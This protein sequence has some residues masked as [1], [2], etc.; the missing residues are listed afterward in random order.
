MFLT[1]ISVF[2][3]VFAVMVMIAIG[4]FGVNAYRSLPIDQYP[5]VDFPVVAIL[6]PWIGAPPES[7]E[8][9]ITEVIENAVNT[10]AG[11]DTISSTSQHSHSTVV[12]MFDLDTDSM[13]AAQEVRD[14]IAAVIPQLP[15]D[16]NSPTVVRFNPTSAP[17]LSLAIS[18]E[19]RS[20]T[21]LTTLAEDVI[22]PALTAIDGVGSANVVGAVEDEVEVLIDPDRLR[23]FNLGV[24]DVVAALRSDN[25]I[26]P[27]GSVIDG[28]L[29]QSVQ[30]NTEVATL[31]ELRAMTIAR[32]GGAAITLGDLAEVR[33]GVS[34]AD[35]RAFR[36][37]LTALAIDVVKVEGGNTVAVA[38]AVLAAVE[39]LQAGPQLGGARIDVLR[40]AATPIE[41]SF[42]TVQATLIEGGLL[43]TAIVFLFLNSW[44]STVITGLTL[45]ISILGTLA[46]I[47]LLG[48]TLNTM[49]MLAL[50]LSIGII[51]DDAI[52]VR[53]NITRHLHMGKDHFEA[54]LVGTS[55]IGFAVLA[56][57]LSICAVFMPLAFMEG[58]V[59]KFFL[60][61]GV[62]VSVAVLVS[63]F[64][65][66]TLDPMLSSVWYDP[67]SQPDARRGPIGRAVAMFERGFE[68][69]AK[70]YR[71]ILIWCL[72]WR[73]TTLAG[74]LG[75]F[76][77]S[78]FLVPLIGA[79]F[80]PVMD[81][82]RLQVEVNAP[83]GSSA[84]YAS[85][86]ANQVSR[87]LMDMPEVESVY[88]SV[89]AGSRSGDHQASLVANLVRPR[90]RALSA[91]ELVPVVREALA[92]IPGVEVLVST[93]GGVGPDQSPITIKVMGNNAVD[94]AQAADRVLAL[95]QAV[96]GTVDARLGSE[97]AQPMLDFVLDR[98]VSTDLGVNAQQV[99]GALRVLISGEE[100]TE[101]NQRDGTS[102]PVVVRLPQ[103]L[104]D[105]AR[106]GL[107]FLPVAQSFG[108]ESP[109]AVT[110]GQIAT[111][112]ETRGPSRIERENLTRVITISSNYAE[113]ILGDVVNDITAGLAT[114]DL[115]P[116][117]TL[118]FGGDAEMLAETT[119]N[120]AAALLMAVVFIYLVIASQFGSFVQPFAIMMALPL[121]LIG[122]LLG[123]MAWGS[124]LNMY[125]MIGFVMLMGLV[126]KNAI[127]L[128]DN[129]NHH[130][131]A[132][133]AVR[134]AM[135]EAGTT[136]FRPIIMTTLAMI[137]GMLPLALAIHEGSEQNASMAHAVIGGLISSTLLTL[138]VVPVML[139][140]ID[141]FSTRVKRFLT[142]NRPAGAH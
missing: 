90:Q 65:S 111:L 121:S 120:M 73:K 57:S 38:Q 135:I 19:S 77:G 11:I 71:R 79:E 55:E 15:S 119:G 117:I 113:R 29:V 82:S 84:D 68:R 126:V 35:G 6:T 93:G 59:G 43:A 103:E 56:T 17:I 95:V 33:W 1:R 66:F 122:V 18:D 21:E 104:R 9:E 2:Q 98:D 24:T 102:S 53:E 107:A 134:E 28:T 114:L 116:G 52:V 63:L 32:Q 31:E 131:N 50:I 22:V 8:T 39:R 37:G 74:A 13:L 128:V 142:R 130:M 88:A 67:A 110:I 46:V 115:P 12:L 129:A 36:N 91:T 80:I 64:V 127:L 81:E 99:G 42:N 123:L 23:A 105:N 30:L 85:I 97:D 106:E 26:L 7:V 108:G 89:G 112:Q 54:A 78:F 47:S 45:P 70:R 58:I 48:F 132:G 109:Q 51:I 41:A 16:A 136:R 60:Q 101:L 75:I 69:L 10:L 125:S 141:G 40:N 5:D 20:L 3:P 124:T 62:T 139:T 83:V 72:N 94:L 86:K 76:V 44:R 4:V 118:N 49:T 92:V 140:Y 133:L 27:A 25:L 14:R 138:V 87:I 96:P 100:V 137:C 34:E 61:F